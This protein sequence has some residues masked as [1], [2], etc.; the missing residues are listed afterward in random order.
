M[1]LLS[2]ADVTRKWAQPYGITVIEEAGWQS[3]GKEFPA[4]GPDVA[5][6]HWTAGSA[7]G[8]WPSGKIL[9]LGRS[10]LPGPLCQLSQDR[11]PA[12]TL[13]CI[14][15]VAS[16]VANHA[17]LGDWN[18]TSGANSVTV[19][20]EIEWSG[21]NEHFSQQRILVSEIAMRALM[22]FCGKNPDDACEHR[23]WANPP[24]RKIDTNLD[25]NVLRRRMAQLAQTPAP[26]PT[27]TPT[28]EE[29]EEVTTIMWFDGN[30]AYA[31]S[32]LMAKYLTSM[33]QVNTLKFIGVKEVNPVGPNLYNTLIIVDGPH[34][35]T[36]GKR[37]EEWGNYLL[38]SIV[39]EVRKVPQWV[40]DGTVP[41]DVDEAA[42]AA[43]LAPLLAG[44]VKTLSDTDIAKV[45]K[46]VNDELARR[47][48][49]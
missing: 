37:I 5:V 3:R 33:D 17:G 24:G 4:A 47:Q 46:A 16:G 42:L 26:T 40:K 38:S 28:P 30:A 34:Q 12:G 7:T 15:V 9:T 6:R 21:P 1:R 25:G 45:S 32:G 43:A 48:A 8:I 2:L 49:D 35:N 41:P 14:R 23:E 22:D 10:D 19:G 18:G 13:D 36:V 27:P 39:G 29:D 20:L 31:V 44:T 11:R